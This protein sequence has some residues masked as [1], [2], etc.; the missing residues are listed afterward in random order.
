MSPHI[1]KKIMKKISGN[2]PLVLDRPAS[3]VRISSFEESSIH[4][5]WINWL[6]DFSQSRKLRGDLQEQLWYALQREGFSFPFSV[7]DVRLTKAISKQQSSQAKTDNLVETTFQLLRNNNLFSTLSNSQISRLIHLSSSCSYGPG[8]IIAIEQES[9]DSLFMLIDGKVSIT[10]G[11][12][13]AGG[14]EIAQLCSGDICG[15]MTVFTDAPRSATIRSN[16]KSDILEI[17][18]HAIA[19]LIEEEPILLERFS[20]LI[21]DRQAKLNSLEIQSIQG[22]RRDVIGRVKELFEKLLS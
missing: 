20:Q 21:S 5:E 17:H 15:E 8:E 14:T 10:K 2:H 6:S 3:I 18:R 16:S 22:S 9:G 12:I 13:A 7:R 4:Y 1:A 19:E 11:D